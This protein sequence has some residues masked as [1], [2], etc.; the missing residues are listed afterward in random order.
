MKLYTM[1]LAAMA[2]G[3]STII[4]PP[5][6][7]HVSAFYIKAYQAGSDSLS[8]LSTRVLQSIG[9][10]HIQPESDLDTLISEA[11]TDFNLNPKLLTA[12][13]YRESAKNSDA[14]SPKSAIGLAQIMPFNAKRCGLPKISKLWDERNNIRCGAQILSEELRSTKGQLNKALQIYNGGPKCVNKCRESITYATLV[15]QKFAELS[16]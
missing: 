7:Y 12:L 6:L 4:V 13:I 11:A 8:S 16:L 5:C 2:L 1:K 3:A 10:T 15:I 14:Y 9:L